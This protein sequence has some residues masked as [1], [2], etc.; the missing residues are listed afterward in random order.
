[1]GQSRSPRQFSLR[2][3]CVLVTLAA[4]L[5]GVYQWRHAI[6]VARQTAR[7]TPL[8]WEP[9]SR[10]A[11]D[12]SLSQGQPVLVVYYAHWKPRPI[13]RIESEE[14]RVELHNQKM[15]VM[16]GNYMDDFFETDGVRAAMQEL[17]PSTDATIFGA[18]YRPNAEP[19][20]FEG[21]PDRLGENAIDALNGKYGG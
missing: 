8:A 19:V 6:A 10:Q 21:Y 17:K 12:D 4:A 20:I 5:L 1:M 3:L 9:F 16:D 18:I 14:L 7:V 15:I 11:L 2:S 13:W